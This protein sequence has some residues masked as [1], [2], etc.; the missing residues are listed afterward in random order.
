MFVVKANIS[1][2]YIKY[3]VSKRTSY[4]FQKEQ[5]QTIVKIKYS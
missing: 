3:N 1:Q 2:A 4:I 5:T